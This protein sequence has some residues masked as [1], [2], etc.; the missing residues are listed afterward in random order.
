MSV[1]RDIRTSPAFPG[2]REFFVLEFPD[3]VNIVAV[4]EDNMVVLVRQYR[5]GVEDFNLEIPGGVVDPGETPLA[6]AARELAEETG[7]VPQSLE[8]LSSVCVNPAIQSNRCHL[9]LAGGCRQLLE[10]NLDGT[11]AIE[12]QLYPL[13]SLEALMTRGEIHH[14]LNCLAIVLA[15]KKLAAR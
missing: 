4:T 3:W 12:V 10:Q 7:Y 1:R 15:L 8:L 9:F 2:R 6:A 13:D 5:Q 11:E 14:S